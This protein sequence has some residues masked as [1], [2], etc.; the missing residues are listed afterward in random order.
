[1]NQP[2]SFK[3]KELLSITNKA[4][5]VLHSGVL[6]KS[7]QN[8]KANE[9]AVLVLEHYNLRFLLILLLIHHQNSPEALPLI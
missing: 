5:T 8:L 4:D 9:Q 1:M 2:Y 6:W 7:E 3:N